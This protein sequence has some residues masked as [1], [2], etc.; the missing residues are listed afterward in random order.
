MIQLSPV[1]SHHQIFPA[2]SL[3]I[4]LLV[5]GLCLVSSLLSASLPYLA[6]VA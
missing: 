3:M 4:M 6:G 2:E 5:W 1:T